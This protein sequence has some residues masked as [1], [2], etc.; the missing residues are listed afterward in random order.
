MKYPPIHY[1]DYLALDSL[2]AA[3]KRKSEEHGRPAHDEMLFIIVHQAYELWFKQILFDLDSVLN[4][5]KKSPVP[6]QE[7]GI[8][9]R[10]LSRITEI[11]KHILGQIDIME[12]MTP[13]DF[14]DFREFL[15]PASGFQSTQ[16]RMIEL[17]MGLRE[18]DRLLYNQSAAFTSLKPDHQKE[19]KRIEAE[20]SLFASIEKWLERTPFVHM[21]NFDF[22]KS[23]QKAVVDM[24]ES[25]KKVI[26]T[27]PRLTPEE[28]TKNTAMMDAQLA[29]F[30]SLFKEEE[31]QKIQ[32]DGHFRLS[33]K[34]FH[35]ALFILLYRDEPIL[36][37]PFR[38]IQ[39]LLD[40]DE[41]WT[42]WRYRHALMAHRM[43]GRKIGTGGSSGSQYLKDATDKHKIFTDFFNM[44]TFLL[45]RSQIPELPKEV[46]ENLGF[47]WGR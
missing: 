27:N 34:A 30:Q 35:A 45:P 42:E 23:Y 24:I 46:K 29:T 20:P 21:Q 1:N 15:Y 18:Q 14:L 11:Q 25:D 38:T 43:L 3:Q 10:Q 8:A 13:L 33:F 2:L 28:K 9:V 47:H 6:D 41:K 4:I 17:K 40:I 39:L 32:K 31:Y 19:M 44:T 37:L 12:T 5:L 16:F 22:W 7:M 26:A 36:Q